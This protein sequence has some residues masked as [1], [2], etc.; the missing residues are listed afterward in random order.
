[1]SNLK[2]LTMEEL[3]ASSNFKPSSLEKGQE[4]EGKI[5]SKDDKE[6]IID[7]GG[8]SEGVLPIKGLATQNN[9]KVGDKIKAQV[10]DIENESGQVLLTLFIASP[11]VAGSKLS[12]NKEIWDKLAAN[13]SSEAVIKGTVTKVT[14]FGVF[15]QLPEGPE[16]LVHS[17]KLGPDDN[18]ESGQEVSVTIDSLDLEKQRISLSPVITS[19]KGLIYK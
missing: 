15:I 13:M 10:Q 1:M 17:S 6:V 16:G 18:F 11:K 2:N 12:I 8:K 4:V 14:Q 9:F 19:T 7:L 3:L 5:L